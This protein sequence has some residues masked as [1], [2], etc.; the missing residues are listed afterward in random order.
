MS[1]HRV[2]YMIVNRRFLSVFRSIAHNIVVCASIR[3][4]EK[5]FICQ[6]IATEEGLSIDRNNWHMNIFSLIGAKA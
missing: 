5:I 2:L 1:I 6:H 4:P 3:R